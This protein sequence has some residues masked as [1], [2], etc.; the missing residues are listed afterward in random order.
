M[1]GIKRAILSEI[2]ND[3]KSSME[4]VHKAFSPEA[5]RSEKGRSNMNG[6]IIAGED[7]GKYTGKHTQDR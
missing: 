6:S 2:M 4:E 7:Q 5:M 3:G 1:S